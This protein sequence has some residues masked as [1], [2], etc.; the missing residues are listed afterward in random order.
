[1]RTKQDEQI[2]NKKQDRKGHQEPAAEV[3]IA[4][5][6]SRTRKPAAT[7]EHPVAVI[8]S[9]E[10][11]PEPAKAPAKTPKTAKRLAA[12][13]TPPQQDDGQEVCVFAFRLLRS[14]RDELHAATGSAK[15]SKFVKAIV[16][17]GARGDMKAIQEI[18]DEAQASRR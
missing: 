9:S 14:E 16:L 4:T 5:G 3:R 18:V 10:T 2:R 6:R 8:V 15:A 7:A 11:P 1:M 12:D 17:A 13:A